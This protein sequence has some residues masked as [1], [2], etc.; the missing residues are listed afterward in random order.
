MRQPSL[1]ATLMAVA[2]L[3]ACADATAPLTPSYDPTQFTDGLIYRWPTGAT[4]AVF[5]DPTAVP[6]GVD[7]AT[8]TATGL[9][10]WKAA[11]GGNEFAFRTATSP[12]DADVIVHVGIAPRLV[13][14]AGCAEPAPYSGGVTFLCP[15]ADSALTLPLSSAAV[16]HVKVDIIVNPDAASAANPLAA[17]VTHELGHAIGIGGHSTDPHDVMYGSPSVAVPSAR[18]I[19]TLRWL[20]RQPMGLRL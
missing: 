2:A 15:A 16:G 12:A 5:A 17:L 13:G 20:V 9:A 6:A 19:A 10:A 4:I 14:L 8:I 1:V 18:D 3:A 7:L 11:L